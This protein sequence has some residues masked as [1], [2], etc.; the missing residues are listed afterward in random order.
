MSDYNPFDWQRQYERED[1]D[2]DT[3]YKHHEKHLAANY[4]ITELQEMLGDA[5]GGAHRQAMIN[6]ESNNRAGYEAAQSWNA[7]AGDGD[8]AIAIRAALEIHELFPE[9]A[10]GVT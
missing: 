10:K 1:V 5:K 4:S 6:L 9:H 2:Y 3:W 8:E 7:T